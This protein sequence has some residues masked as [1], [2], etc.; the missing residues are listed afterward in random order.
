MATTV[1]RPAPNSPRIPKGVEPLRAGQG[2]SFLLRR[3][4]SLSG[5]VPVGAFL[6]EHLISNAFATNGPDA[7]NNQ[8]KFLT[9]LPF[10]WALEWGFI[11]LP[12]AFHALYGI[13]IWARGESNTG[14]YPWMGN[15]MY[16][17]QRWTGILA[18]AYIVYHVWY[19]RFAG[20]HLMVWWEA[21]FWKVNNEFAKTWPIFVYVIGI[22]ASAWHFGYGVFLFAVKWGLVTGERARKRM[23][24][25]GVGLS[26]ALMAIGLASIYAFAKPKPE[27]PKQEFRQEWLGERP[28]VHKDSGQAQPS[29]AQ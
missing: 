19:M 13:Y 14:D 8:V 18:F 15:W 20:V 22:L 4:H 3:L 7:Y 11:L 6:L 10:T 1:S 12:L 24:M 16:T 21:S 27:W 2:N 29:V 17:L 5:I 23:Q 26:V 9:S 28:A 25:V